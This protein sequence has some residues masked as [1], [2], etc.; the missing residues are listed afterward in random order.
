V[1]FDQTL[2]RTLYE[3]YPERIGAIKTSLPNWWL[4]LAGP[5]ATL[6][7]AATGT[8]F[9][10]KAA[11][12]VGT[13]ATALVADVWR[14]DTVPGANDNLSGVA[15]LVALAERLAGDPPAGLRILLAS[16]GAEETLQD[17]I[18]AFIAHHGHELP[19]ERTIFINLDQVGSPN[20]CMLEAEGPV[21]MEEYPGEWLRDD[22][23]RSAEALG[24]PLE[25]GFR[26]RSSTDG[27]IPARRGHAT[28]TLFSMTDWRTIGEYHLP[29]DT[30][31]NIDWATLSDAVRLVEDVIGGLATA[32]PSGPAATG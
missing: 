31:E 7:A 17:G 28:A 21:W 27:V 8:R 5:L 25:R 26:A 2:V 24:I 11:A 9:G 10:A 22:I 30:P 18:R 19:P 4:G 12:G 3:R 16:C 13:F 20:M 1:I 32:A 29:T 14:N 15:A 6:F 23:A